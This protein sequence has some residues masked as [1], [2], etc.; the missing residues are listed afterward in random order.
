MHIYILLS[1][2]PGAPAEN[3]RYALLIRGIANVID[4]QHEDPPHFLADLENPSLGPILM[5]SVGDDGLLICKSP[6]N[7]ELYCFLF[8]V[9]LGLLDA[10]KDLL[11]IIRNDYHL[12]MVRRATL[13]INDMPAI[14]RFSRIV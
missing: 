14:Q 1:T 6:L 5:D 3:G 9:W 12:L 7:D 4:P 8:D 10:N 2:A 11:R 13:D